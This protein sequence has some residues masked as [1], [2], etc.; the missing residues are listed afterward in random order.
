MAQGCLLSFCTISNV[1]KVQVQQFLLDKDKCWEKSFTSYISVYQAGVKSRS[2]PSGKK[3]NSNV[4]ISACIF[5]SCSLGAGQGNHL[6][7]NTYSVYAS[8]SLRHSGIL[9]CFDYIEGGNRTAQC[10]GVIGSICYQNAEPRVFT[11]VIN[12]YPT[13]FPVL[14]AMLSI[15]KTYRCKHETNKK[16]SFSF[17]GICHHF[18]RK[19]ISK[20][21]W[22]I[23]GHPPKEVHVLVL[24]SILN[25][26][27]KE[28]MESAAECLLSSV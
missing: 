23:H 10:S 21:V 4:C 14:K 22:G 15:L 9:L 8:C 16:K 25:K 7:G 19:L 6:A 20:V 3:S 28:L 12:K 24:S 26:A 5:S 27:L 2:C 18:S 13:W 1:F 17:C 11:H